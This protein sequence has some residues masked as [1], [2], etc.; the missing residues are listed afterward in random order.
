M[1]KGC[2]SLGI[3]ALP[4]YIYEIAKKSEED[5]DSRLFV[6]GQFWGTYGL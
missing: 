1:S 4:I 5:V 2:I 6:T 3:L